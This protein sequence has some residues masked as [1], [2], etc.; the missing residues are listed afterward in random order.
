MKA[1][2]TV[3]VKSGSGTAYS[4]I[5]GDGTILS[6]EES[7]EFVLYED[8]VSVQHEGDD[9]SIQL[10]DDDVS[11][12]PVDY[13]NAL[14]AIEEAAGTIGIG[15][16]DE[17]RDQVDGILFIENSG[18]VDI[19]VRYYGNTGEANYLDI[20]LSPDASQVAEVTHGNKQTFV[21]VSS[22]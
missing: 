8:D 22:S 6:D 12:Q 1:A 11:S 13:S 4:D 15:N 14:N 18:D 7:Q 21:L 16:A 10:E 17:G 19:T 2:I 9:I 3:G 5:T 20:M